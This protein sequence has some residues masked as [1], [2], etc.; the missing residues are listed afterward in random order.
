MIQ[1]RRNPARHSSRQPA[2]ARHDEPLRLDSL[3]DLGALHQRMKAQAREQARQ[4]A[5]EQRQRALRMQEQQ[6]FAQAVGPVQALKKV[7]HDPPQR[8]RPVPSAVQTWRDE[9]DVLRSTL[10]DEFDVETL[11]DTDDGLHFRREGI[12]PEVVRKLR[13]GAWA[14]QAQ[15]DLHGLR[16][17]EAREKLS[18]FIREAVQAG[19]RCVRVVHGKGHG[20]PGGQPVLKNK[21]KSWLA[22]KEEVLAYTT[23]RAS[24]GGHGALL[25]LLELPSRTPKTMTS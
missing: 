18:A 15:I 12:S 10:S 6:L 3:A 4:K 5:L 19:L 23:A 21:V 25:V 24:D 2:R 9:Q 1:T 14:L 13:R 7:F 11:L 22:Q 20:S 8:P 17:E 16:R